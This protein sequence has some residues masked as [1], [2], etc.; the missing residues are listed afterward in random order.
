VQRLADQR[1]Y[2]C[3]SA[4]LR[5]VRQARLGTP[6]T[7]NTMACTASP[8]VTINSEGPTELSIGSISSIRRHTPATT[9]RWSKRCAA[10]LVNSIRD[11]LLYTDLAKITGKLPRGPLSEAAC[12]ISLLTN[13]ICTIAIISPY[14]CVADIEPGREVENPS[15]CP[16]LSRRGHVTQGRGHEGSGHRGTHGPLRGH[17]GGSPRPQSDRHARRV[18]GVRPPGGDDAWGSGGWAEPQGLGVCPSPRGRD[19]AMLCQPPPPRPTLRWVVQRLAEI[20]RVRGTV[21]GRGPARM[22]GRHDVQRNI[23]RLLGGKGLPSV[24]H[25]SRSGLLNVGRRKIPQSFSDLVAFHWLF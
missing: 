17:G 21:P 16:C 18:W 10:Q 3:V 25:A 8:T 5:A 11:L 14:S 24:S 19:T 4:V 22:E 1:F 9:P 7:F 20:H 12:G 15:I 2:W 13:D 6:K 23:L